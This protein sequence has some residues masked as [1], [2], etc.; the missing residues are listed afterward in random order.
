MYQELLVG[1]ISFFASK[2][3]ISNLVGDPSF[4]PYVC[5]DA[6]VVSLALDGTEDY[7]CLA[8]DGF[9]DV[10]QPGDVPLM[11]FQIWLF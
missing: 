7:L 3:S 1:T 4:K 6:D 5:A 9:W 2:T 8:C 11:V 10:F